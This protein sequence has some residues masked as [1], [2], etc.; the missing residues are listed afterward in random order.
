[1]TDF[2][3]CLLKLTRITFDT[4]FISSLAIILN[5]VVWENPLMAETKKPRVDFIGE[6]DGGWYW[7]EHQIP[8]YVP[9]NSNFNFDYSLQEDLLLPSEFFYN[10]NLPQDTLNEVRTVPSF[11]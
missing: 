6:L 4:F 8:N 11:F 7:G 2:Y 5:T 3:S 10:G 9:V 1:M